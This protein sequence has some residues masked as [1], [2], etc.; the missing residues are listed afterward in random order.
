MSPYRWVAT[1]ICAAF[2][3]PACT[4]TPSDSVGSTIKDYYHLTDEIAHALD[5]RMGQDP[6]YQIVR[7]VGADYEVGSI[8]AGKVGADRLTR[9]CVARKDLIGVN[10]FAG[11]P[12][13]TSGRV[14]KFSAGADKSPIPTEVLQRLAAVGITVRDGEE[15]SYSIGNMRQE[16]V[17]RADLAELVDGN[18]ACREFI[19]G[20]AE[21]KVAI[22]RGKI[23]GK[24][25]ISS[26]NFT[27]AGIG[28]RF[29]IGS[30]D[31]SYDTNRG[32]IVAFCPN[33]ALG[34]STP[35]KYH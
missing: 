13:I 4:G 15:L 7:I 18:P 11:L 23:A 2:F 17:D 20:L 8:L 1:V 9:R 35:S 16:L 5:D 22:V 21:N 10:P 12:S 33:K 26:R 30:F 28:G 32:T 29:G 6:E 14:L 31:V 19:D 3:V 27:S 25:N 34:S 24:E